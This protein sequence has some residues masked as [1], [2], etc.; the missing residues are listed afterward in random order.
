MSKRKFIL[1]SILKTS[2]LSV[3]ISIVF[4]II[5]LEMTREVRTDM[6]DHP[7]RCDMSG[8]AYVLTIFWLLFLSLLSFSSLFS[9]LPR[10]QG[11]ISRAV[12][13]LFLPVAALLYSSYMSII[14]NGI[15]DGK[16]IVFFLILNLPWFALWLFFYKRFNVRYPIA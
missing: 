1:L 14:T 15:M 13:W 12:C 4:L 10:F 3:C 16:D 5:F 2:L 9:L 11:K 8:L 7:A 6:Y